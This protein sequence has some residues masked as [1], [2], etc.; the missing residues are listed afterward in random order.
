MEFALNRRGGV[1]VR[2]QLVA[3]LE[4]KIL[5]GA[6]A[7]GQKLPSVRA[8]A[9]RLDIHANTVSAAYRDLEAAGVVRLQRGAGV[10]VLARSGEDLESARGLDEMIRSALRSAFRRG[11]TGREIRTAVERWLAASPPDRLAVIDP[12]VDVAALV[13][14]ELERA[15]EKPVSYG[16][17][18]DAAR[19]PGLLSGALAVTSPYHVEALREAAPSA[20][21]EVIHLEMPEDGRRTVGA[22]PAGSI[23]LVVVASATVQGF[24]RTLL[25]SLRGDEI[26]VEAHRLEATRQWRRLAAAADL[27]IAD[28]R[29]APAV[30]RARPRR[31]YVARLVQPSTLERLRDALTVVLPR[32]A[33]DGGRSS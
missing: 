7:P 11:Y 17:V 26:H 1:P 27:V 23:V 8:L 5:E 20:A 18:A 14:Y 4:M 10:F 9:R 15:L 19:D 30:E 28:L 29:S 31:L 2:D 25:R 12:A 13:A 3:Q 32:P 16:S 33:K 22:L 6:L 24:A 21:I